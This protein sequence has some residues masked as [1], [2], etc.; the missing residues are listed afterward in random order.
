MRPSPAAM[1]NAELGKLSAICFNS[2]LAAAAAEDSTRDDGRDTQ[3]R[4]VTANGRDHYRHT[5]DIPV[6]LQRMMTSLLP[7]QVLAKVK[8]ASPRH[9]QTF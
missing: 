1:F 7:R 2:A 6:A 8:R 3:E 4:A 9:A 5:D